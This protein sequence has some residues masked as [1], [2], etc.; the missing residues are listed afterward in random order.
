MRKILTTVLMV[1]MVM[2]CGICSAQI[3]EADLNIGG[4]YIGQSMD[5]IVAKYGEPVRTVSTP[6]VGKAYVFIVDGSEIAVAPNIKKKVIGIS[7]SENS[8]L[9]LLSGIGLYAPI[10]SIIKTY[11]EPDFSRVAWKTEKGNI[12]HF[13]YRTLERKSLELDGLT[14]YNELIFV[15]DTNDNVSRI[16]VNTVFPQ[17][18]VMP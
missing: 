16:S 13:G 18:A 9:T 15:I 12:T 3:A 4:V 5:E 11:G 10:D 2:V 8:N 1:M 7:I 6:P 17:S 14:V